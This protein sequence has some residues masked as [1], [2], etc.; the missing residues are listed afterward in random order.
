MWPLPVVR[1]T[2]NSPACLLVGTV[3]LQ[4]YISALRAQTVTH[5]HPTREGRDREEWDTDV[6]EALPPH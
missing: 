1:D 2:K 3:P 4:V 6:V 5:R